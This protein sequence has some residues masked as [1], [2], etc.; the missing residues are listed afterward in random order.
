MT[1]ARLKTAITILIA[2]AILST[3]ISS[4]A[5]IVHNPV[6]ITS[7]PTSSIVQFSSNGS[8]SVV[9]VNISNDLSELNASISAGGFYSNSSRVSDQV[10]LNN[11]S[12]TV[13]SKPLTGFMATQNS[14]TFQV[15]GSTNF[16]GILYSPINDT[17][18]SYVIAPSNA[19]IP[20]SSLFLFGFNNATVQEQSEEF[21]TATGEFVNEVSLLLSGN[22][23]FNFSMGSTLYGS[24]VASNESVVV[25]GTN[26]YNISIPVTFL[27]GETP[28]Y[29]NLYMTSGNPA[30]RSV[31]QANVLAGSNI[32]S[33]GNTDSFISVS[34]YAYNYSLNISVEASL[35]SGVYSVGFNPKLGNFPGNVA[36]FYEYGLK[37]GTSWSVLVNGSTYVTQ[38]KFI[39]VNGTQGTTAYSTL[40]V[41]G[42]SAVY[43]YGF[44]YQSG[45]SIVIPLVFHSDTTAALVGANSTHLKYINLNGSQEFTLPNGGIINHVS[46]LLKG[47]GRVNISIG[48]SLSGSQIMRNETVSVNGSSWYSVSVPT[49][50]FSGSTSYFLNVYSVNGTVQWA[51]SQV[52]SAV[53]INTL[54]SY[55]YKSGKLKQSNSWVYILNLTYIEQEAL[56]TTGRMIFVEYGLPA[57]TNWAVDMLSQHGINIG[58][59]ITSYSSLW[60]AHADMI[61]ISGPSNSIG[62]SFS[63][64]NNTSTRLQFIYTPGSLVDTG[65]AVGLTPLTPL[66]MGITLIPYNT[67]A[68]KETFSIY[69]VAHSGSVTITLSMA[70]TVS[71]SF[72]EI[73]G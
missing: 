2:L 18:Y 19:T 15:A 37:S 9:A 41:P 71:L 17:N 13:F 7:S 55:F 25:T 61:A 46:I 10:T 14:T 45:Y 32:S 11:G 48:Y 50:F 16:S 57:G 63:L 73:T 62:L 35:L 3:G 5:V 26:Y 68:V 1:G 53:S 36:I 12:Y 58:S 8:S 34:L 28:Y 40:P 56:D 29:L 59:V 31:I 52:S 44:Y 70:L 66:V 22:G 21:T 54:H 6:L 33:Y 51:H 38:G 42:Y 69:M 47:S 24:Q 27:S 67:G 60:F 43:D 72:Y 30:W 64:S 23:T 4:A 65:S 49:I 39:E 20:P